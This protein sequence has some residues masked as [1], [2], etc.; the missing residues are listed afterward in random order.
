MHSSVHLYYDTYREFKSRKSNGV[1]KASLIF[2]S[3]L[4]LFGKIKTAQVQIAIILELTGIFACDFLH[5]DPRNNA[6]KALLEKQEYKSLSF[7]L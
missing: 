1:I 3:C 7:E 4:K 5:R 6:F 2:M